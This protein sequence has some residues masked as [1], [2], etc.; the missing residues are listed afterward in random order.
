MLCSRNQVFYLHF[1][2]HKFLQS[3]SIIWHNLRNSPSQ[4]PCSNNVA[5]AVS[6]ICL[7]RSFTYFALFWPP[8]QNSTHWSSSLQPHQMTHR[9][10]SFSPIKFNMEYLRVTSKINILYSVFFETPL[11][12]HKYF[13]STACTL[14]LC[15]SFKI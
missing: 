9:L 11:V 12:L 1:V 4:F 7:S 2:T 15:L 3:L 10:N 14:L 13:I 5:T 6:Q 8:S